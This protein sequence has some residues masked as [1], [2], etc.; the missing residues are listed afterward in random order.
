MNTLNNIIERCHQRHKKPLRQRKTIITPAPY[1]GLPYHFTVYCGHRYPVRLYDLEQ[2]NISFMPIGHAPQHD[3][4][5]RSFD[6]ERFTKRQGIEDWE[7]RRWDAS[8]GIQMYTGTPSGRDGAQWHDLNFSYN[9]LCTAPDTVL[10]CIETLVNAV[11]NPLLTLSKSGGLRFSCRVQNY[12]HSKAEDAKQYIYKH[13]PTPENPHQ[14][15]RYL[16]IFGEEGYNRWD[17]RYEILLGN[18]LNPPIITKDVLFDPINVLQNALHE[19]QPSEEKNL[20]VNAIPATITP[21]SLGSYNLDLAK[22]AFLKR[23]FTYVQQENGYHCWTQHAAKTDDDII[24]LWESEDTVWVR[25]STPN[26]G[27]PTDAVAITDI[28]D[29]TGILPTTALSISDNLIAIREGNLSPLALKRPLPVLKKPEQKKKNYDTFE[30]N[31]GRIQRVY[32]STARITVL[33]AER[34]A[35]KTFSAGSYVLNGSAISLNASFWTVEEVV[36]HFQKRNIQ[37]IE[38]WRARK[39]QWNKVKDIPVEARMAN[40]FQHGN[41]CEDFERCDALEKRGGNPDEIICP[42]CPVYTECQERGYLSQPARLNSVNAQI[43]GTP[44]QFFDPQYTEIVEKFLEQDDGTD[45]LCIVDEIYPNNFFIECFIPIKILMEWSINWQEDVL[46]QFAQALLHALEMNNNPNENVVGRI[47]TAVQAFQRHEAELVKQMCQVKMQGRIISRGYVDVETGEEL[48]QFSIEFEGGVS[49]YIP[50]DNNAMDKLETKGL[51]HFKLDTFAVNKD[52]NIPM[53]MAKAIQLGILNTETVQ[54]IQKFPAVCQYPNW[55]LWHQLKY[56]LAHYERNADAPMIVHFD[57]L[58]FWVPP[59]LHPSIKRLL[60][61]SAILSEQDVRRAFP[62]EEIDYVPI[63]PAA[64]TKG[65]QVFQI[66]TGTY[67]LETILDYYDSWDVIRMSKIGQRFFLNIRSE[68][69]RDPSVKHAIITYNSAIRHLENISELENVCFITAFEQLHGLETAFEEPQVV[70]IVG[71]PPLPPGIIWRRAQILF[72][73]SEE[74]LC[75]ER[76]T[77][78]IRYKD[79]RVQSV[80]QT[81]V[82]VRLKNIIGLT[83]LTRMPNKKVVLV[84]SFP[85]TDI[86]DRPETLLFDWEDFEVAGGLDKLAETIAT[87][88]HYETERD[89]LNADSGRDKVQQVLGCSISTAN[90]VLRKFRGGKLLRVPIREQILSLLADSKKKTVELRE[91]IEGHPTAIKNELKRLV[92]NGE[93]VKVQKGVY[94]LPDQKNSD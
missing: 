20:K 54:S 12:L 4:G 43:S 37:P 35:G 25:A 34:G 11:A 87:R 78:P 9:A 89:N 17:S 80:Y 82:V 23:S 70:W 28:W 33:N 42:K 65:N 13:T 72:G 69:E 44:Y 61:M 41:V 45:R 84:T 7:I 60:L 30:Q 26:I 2:A 48:A 64:W 59:V 31:T 29:D 40:P 76:E 19:P 71:T 15:E 51:P 38:R 1:K 53:P 22:E 36:R 74:P 57:V 79:K 81:L 46:G 66:R 90:R 62:D 75:Y 88:E 10:L 92:D 50:L 49:A 21:V 83:G 68:I 16:E 55:T 52:I 94:S 27:L 14:R 24:F 3:Y 47:R 58:W 8:W 93:I 5:P 67:P 32:D 77:E 73:N 91:G 85:L 18:L 63:E 39:R 6:G 56:Y 86:T